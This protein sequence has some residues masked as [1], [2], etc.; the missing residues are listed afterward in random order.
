[1]R[2]VEIINTELIMTDLDQVE[3]LIPNLQK[4]GKTTNNKDDIKL[5]ELLTQIKTVLLE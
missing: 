5:A 3:R 4:R 1:M 2:D